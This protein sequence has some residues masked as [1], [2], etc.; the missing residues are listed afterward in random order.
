MVYLPFYFLKVSSL[1]EYFQLSD[2]TLLSFF[3]FVIKLFFFLFF[4][5]YHIAI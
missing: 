2:Q 3:H 5:Y 4:F 1:I